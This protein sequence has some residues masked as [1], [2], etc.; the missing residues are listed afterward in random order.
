MIEIALGEYGVQEVSGEA[1]NPRILKYF[2]EIG[3]T[4]VQ[5]EE[6]AWCSSFMNWVALKAG[7]ER[8]GA[9]NA[10]SWLNVGQHIDNP[11]PGDVVVLWRESKESWKGHVGIFVAQTE[12]DIY[13]LGGN[14]SDRVQ[15]SLYP[16]GRILGYRRLNLNL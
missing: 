5:S 9:L 6:T 4:W 3:E 11:I 7:R 13:C 2:E 10:R 16:K 14:Q 8:S 12:E 1:N 15:I